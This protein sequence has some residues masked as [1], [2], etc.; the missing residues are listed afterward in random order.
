MASFE[1]IG[2]FGLTEPEVGS[3]ASRGLLTTAERDGDEWILNGQ[4]EVDRQ[5]PFGDLTVIWARDVS[6]DR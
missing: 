5:R 1:Q 4:Q 2:S 3:G 6:T